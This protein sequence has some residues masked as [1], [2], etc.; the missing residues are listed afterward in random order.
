MSERAKGKLTEGSVQGHVISMTIPM[1]WGLAAV[2]TFNVVDTFFVG[3][4]GT[5]E[6][7]AMSFTFPVIMVFFSLCIGLSAGASSVVARGIGEGDKDAVKRLVTNSM[8]LTVLIVAVFCVIGLATIDPLFTAMGATE[9]TLPLVRE[10]MEIWYLGFIFLAA[11]MVGNACI[12]ATGNARFPAIIMAVSGGINIILDPILIFGLLGAPRLELQGAALATVI[13][14]AIALV[15]AFYVL[16]FK[17]DLIGFNVGTI[18][19]IKTAWAKVLQVGLPAAA[20][21]LITPF[22]MILVTAL[23]ATHG[24]VA[25]AAFGVATRLESL[26]LVVIFAMSSI[27]GPIA[28]QNWGAGLMER[29][30]DLCRTLI[31]FSV[32]YGVLTAVL[33]ALVAPWVTKAFT[34][35][36][37]VSDLA[38]LYLWIVPFSYAGYAL[39][40]NAA[41]LFNGIGKPALGFAMT[42]IRM[43]VIYLPAAWLLGETYGIF[44]VFW[45]AALANLI[46]GV[47]CVFL[48]AKRARLWIFRNA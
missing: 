14:R 6:L 17:E 18:A 13:A 36:P 28:G 46:V 2:I 9:E 47:F 25:V 48:V 15:A 33:L 24:A 44:G 23:V 38:T 45:A 21:N 12:R 30:R 7:A 8:L 43:A 11:P 34:P 41:A 22:A 19:E 35:D 10:Y 39:L 3:Q 32:L 4:L 40:Q 31:R 42:V 1:M 27:M 29:V 37:A 5:V 16:R 20:T 26:A